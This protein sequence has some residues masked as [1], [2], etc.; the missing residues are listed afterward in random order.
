VCLGCRRLANW[1]Q[2]ALQSSFERPN[3]AQRCADFF[4]ARPAPIDWGRRLLGRRG[5][6]GRAPPVVSLQPDAR[7]SLGDGGGSHGSVAG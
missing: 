5:Q 6:R 4:I 2:V 3:G 1:K 7:S